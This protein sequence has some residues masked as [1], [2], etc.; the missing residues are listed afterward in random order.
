MK[1]RS[2]QRLLVGTALPMVLAATAY[3]CKDYLTENA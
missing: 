1:K 3:G 2:K